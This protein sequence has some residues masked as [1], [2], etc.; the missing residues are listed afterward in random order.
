MVRNEDAF[1]QARDTYKDIYTADLTT[2]PSEDLVEMIRLNVMGL[3]F[4]DVLDVLRWDGVDLLRRVWSELL[5][6]LLDKRALFIENTRLKLRQKIKDDAIPG[7]DH[8]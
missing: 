8:L 1:Q 5:S 3:L 6:R 2:I 4:G 7:F